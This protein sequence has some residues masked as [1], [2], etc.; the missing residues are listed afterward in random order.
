MSDN[1]NKSRQA[2]KVSENI[3]EM[4]ELKIFL[5]RK[6]IETEALKKIMA[7]LNTEEDHTTN[8]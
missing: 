1:K 3:D 2:K 4:E 6:K 5:E 7:K 8:K